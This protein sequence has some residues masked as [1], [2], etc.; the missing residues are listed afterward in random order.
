MVPSL[1]RDGCD[2]S[3]RLRRARRGRGAVA[4]LSRT[5][6]ILAVG[7]PVGGMLMM[8]PAAYSAP[9]SEARDTGPLREFPDNLFGLTVVDGTTAYA[10]GYHGMIKVTRDGGT[11]WTTVPFDSTDLLRRV[12]S[13]G[14]GVAFAVSHRG[15]ILKSDANGQNWQV[16]YTEPATYLR[17]I[18][19]V[20]PQVGW[21]VGHDAVILHTKDGGTTWQKETLSGYTLRDQPRFSG[22]VAVSES[23]AIAVGEF[24][25]IAETRDGG[26]SWQTISVKVLPTMLSVAVKGDRGVAVGLTGTVAELS[27]PD[28]GPVQLVSHKSTGPEHFLSVALSNDGQTA[29]IGGMSTLATW[30]DGALSRAN[31]DPKFDIEHSWMGG[32]AIGPDGKALSVGLMGA[33]LRADSLSGQFTQQNLPDAK[34][35]AMPTS[36]PAG[37]KERAETS[38]ATEKV[39]Q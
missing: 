34:P 32:V 29:L 38:A 19:F 12:V 13:V 36:G 4:L 14:G 33:I 24:G 25:T 26:A 18:S 27:V 5:A 17:D 23:R 7:L 9:A 21:V 6:L 39:T 8:A 31:V 16:V 15:N 30:R 37:T 35:G 1:Q 11:S 20:T 2:L 22:V 28:D 10:S 3:R